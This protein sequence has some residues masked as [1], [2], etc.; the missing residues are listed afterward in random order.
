MS[1]TKAIYTYICECPGSTNNQIADA[2]K[3]TPVRAAALTG[4]MCKPTAGGPPRLRREQRKAESGRTVYLYFARG[5]VSR[6]QVSATDQ[7]SSHR[8][9]STLDELID[10]MAQQIASRIAES[11]GRQLATHLSAILPSSSAPQFDLVQYLKEAIVPPQPTQEAS[12]ARAARVLIVG[13][14]PQQ[15]GLISAEFGQA[16]N[17]SFWKEEGMEKLKS[18]CKSADHIV[19]FSSKLGHHVENTIKSTNRDFKRVMGG[20][21]E[22]R[23]V[24]NELGV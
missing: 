8:K 6:V 23:R 14:L 18:L 7:P 2:L 10:D 21:T 16:Y 13:L 19:T 11:V 9:D 24:L 4:Q 17:L 22:L 20:M 15:A 5:A 1:M 3:M 12:G